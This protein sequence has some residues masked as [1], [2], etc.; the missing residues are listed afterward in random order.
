MMQSKYK[1]HWSSS[2]YLTVTDTAKLRAFVD[3]SVS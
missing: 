2:L 1:Y 3:S